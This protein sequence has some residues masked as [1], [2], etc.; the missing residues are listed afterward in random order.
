MTD[1]ERFEKLLSGIQREGVDK[2]LSFIQKSDFYTAPASTRFHLSCEGGLLKHS[3]HV[4]EC[5]I[6]KR[7]SPIWS[8]ILSN[9]SDETLVIVSLL[10]DLCKTYFYVKDFRN[11]KT[12]EPEK[13]SA[14]SPREVKHDAKGDYIWETVPTYTIENKYPL[15]HGQKSVYFILQYMKLSMEEIA[16]ITHHMGAYCDSSQ[17]N[18]L[19]EAY[20]KWPLCL[21]LHEADAEATHLLEKD[22]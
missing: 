11:Q 12:Y 6:A 15:G 20:E 19:G 1:I 14:A 16:A 9:V 13:V 7:N 2:L 21:A 4:Y 17:W 8:N 10:H 18:E 3:L 5:L 22:L